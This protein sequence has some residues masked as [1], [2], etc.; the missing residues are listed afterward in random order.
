[1]VTDDNLNDRKIVNYLRKNSSNDKNQFIVRNKILGLF[2][3]TIEDIPIN[4]KINDDKIIT[5]KIK[6]F[7]NYFHSKTREEILNLFNDKVCS[8][9]II[10][11]PFENLYDY[12]I[13][14][15]N[16]LEISLNT[17]RPYYYQDWKTKAE[18]VNLIEFKYQQS[19]Y[20][21]YLN[22][23]LRKKK[24]PNFNEFLTFIYL[25]TNKPVHKDIKNVFENIEK[26]Y[27]PIKEYI[28]TKNL[29]FKDVKEILIKSVSIKNRIEL[30]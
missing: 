24:F 5:E 23:Y 14:N 7:P 26:S 1:M 4:S 28:N 25:K 21:M 2:Y 20:N 3:D 9:K 13:Q 19:F 11:Y 30:Q 17:F 10:E 16:N 27:E 18:L 15:K 6:E 12:D 29:S 22:Y 8:R